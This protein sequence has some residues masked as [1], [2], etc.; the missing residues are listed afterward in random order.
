ML[1]SPSWQVLVT[2]DS[3]RWLLVQRDDAPAEDRARVDDLADRLGA[4]ATVRRT[5]GSDDVDAAIDALEG[6]A[7]VVC[8]GDGSIHLVANRLD[9]RG[10]LDDTVVGLFPAGT[11]NDL[12]HTLDLP[13]DPAAMAELLRTGRRTHLDLLRV[14]DQGVA[15]NAL[16]AGVGVDAAER[17]QSLPDGLGA[18]AYPVGALLAGLGA[19]GFEGEVRVDDRVVC[20]AEGGNTLMVLVLNGRTIGG[21]HEF[22]P[23]ADPADGILHVLICQAV[24]VAARGAFGLAVTRG[25][26]LDRDDVLVEPGR[27]VEVIGPDLTWN[28]DGE[29]WVDRPV[30]SLAVEVEPGA[31]HLLV[32]PG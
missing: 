26:H 19:R 21:G 6:A 2:T 28:V 10:R 18:L 1:S 29:L 12:A 13:H 11:G 24:G 4:G 32:P 14:G 23:D 7:L 20:R 8:G 22:V 30:D 31:L 27:R 3:T 25:T 17:S 9:A 15:V 5:A 16:H